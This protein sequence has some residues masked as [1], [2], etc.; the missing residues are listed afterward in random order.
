M[1][2]NL[3]LWVCISEAQERVLWNVVG[4]FVV[5]F[6]ILCVK[7][8]ALKLYTFSNLRIPKIQILIHCHRYKLDELFVS[9]RSLIHALNM[10]D[11]LR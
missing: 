3:V 8:A 9:L 1:E 5:P 10:K 11:N 2:A 7:R 6:R 4:M